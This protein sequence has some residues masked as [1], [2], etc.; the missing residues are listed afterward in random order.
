MTDL[1]ASAPA[2]MAARTAAVATASGAQHLP[3]FLSSVNPNAKHLDPRLRSYGELALAEAEAKLAPASTADFRTQLTACLTLVAPTGMSPED[4]TEW[5]LAAWG[6]LKDIPPDLLEAGCEVARETCDHPSK[7]VPAIMK[8]ADTSWR[9]RKGDRARVLAVL[10]LPSEVE[11]VADE[12]R[13]T[14][15]QAAEILR[16]VG[17]APAETVETRAHR[18]PPTSP[19]REDYIRWGVDPADIPNSAASEEAA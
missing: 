14:P 8:L 3:R 13:C 15:E 2:A 5:L 10:A 17:I 6:T 1:T 19:T 11:E 7:I 9:K 12:D 4:R 16:Q 18:G